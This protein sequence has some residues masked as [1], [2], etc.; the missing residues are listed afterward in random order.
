MDY[1]LKIT[2][3]RIVDGSGAPGYQGDVGV[4]DGKIAG[5]GNLSK[6][7][8]AKT[9][10]AAGLVVSPGFID[11]HT[12]MD[13]QIFWDPWATSVPF[14]GVT[15]IVMGNCGLTLA[16][17][18]GGDAEPL[19]KS[20]VRVEA[21]PRSIVEDGVPFGWD[22]YGDYL[23]M[24][25][26]KVGVNVGGLVGHHAVRH[27]V[28]GEEAVEREATNEEITQMQAVLRKQMQGGALGLSS[29]VRDHHHRTDGKPVASRFATAEEHGALGDVLGELNAGIYMVAGP[30]HLTNEFIVGSG[31]LSERIGRPVVWLVLS[32]YRKDG[33]LW[34]EQLRT[35]E[36]VFENGQR[37]Y[38]LT[39]AQATR[40]RINLSGNSGFDEYPTWKN[41]MFLPPEVK[42]QAFA[43]PETR[44]KM[45][46]E[47]ANLE[48]P[49]DPDWDNI[50]IIETGKPENE[51]Y[52]KKSISEMAADRGQDPLDAFIDLS[53]EEDLKTTYQRPDSKDPKAMGEIISSPYVVAGLS[54]AGA[55]LQNLATFGY[56]TTLL[57]LW[58]R[59]RGVLTLEQAVNK[60]TGQVAAIWGIEGRGLL[61]KGYAA[62]ITL[63]DPNTVMSCDSEWADDLPGGVKRLVQRAVGIHYTIVNG[64]I[65]CED[66]HLTDAIPGQI[67]RGNAYVGAKEL[68]KV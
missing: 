22:S 14:H 11:H 49:F 24:L 66:G 26:G 4:K 5:I 50:L 59:E 12:H 1:D 68:A 34:E 23:D 56:G 55:H 2:G 41:V 40:G 42:K 65:I 60:L 33:N 36:G 15:S 64:Q 61:R 25:E 45:R 44:Q 6:G 53:I 21:I 62:D 31:D 32:H 37:A 43:D 46:W 8:A 18:K 51:K 30:S 7:S 17:I 58:Y 57:G 48:G 47:L 63:F 10:D 38:A 52:L 3:G 27:Y 67:L 13:A 54:D 28:M 9:I 39:V 19:V 20:L 29:S 16:P 35:L